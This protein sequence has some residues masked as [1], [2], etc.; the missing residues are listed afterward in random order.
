MRSQKKRSLE[1]P[2]ALEAKLDREE[3]SQATYGQE[4]K[5]RERP[6]WDGGSILSYSG[7]LVTLD[8]KVHL[9]DMPDP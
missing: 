8:E 3:G 9:E 4:A 7:R 6:R 2:L 1:N 5:G